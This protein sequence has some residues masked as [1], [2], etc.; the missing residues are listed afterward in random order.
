MEPDVNTSLLIS[1]IGIGPRHKESNIELSNFIIAEIID[2]PVVR[3]QLDRQ[4]KLEFVIILSHFG[5]YW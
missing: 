5:R 4:P 2:C 3:K 1:P